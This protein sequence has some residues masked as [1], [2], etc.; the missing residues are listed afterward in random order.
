MAQVTTYRNGNGNGASNW[1]AIGIAGMAVTL[2][3]LNGF[4]QVAN[5]REDLKGLNTRFESVLSLREH[6]EFR[7]TL[8][9]SLDRLTRDVHD[10]EKEQNLRIGAVERLRL[11]EKITDELRKDH[12]DLRKSVTTTVTISGALEKL[13][14]EQIMLRE[15]INRL[16]T[17]NPVDFLTPKAKD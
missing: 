16:S 5:P 3:L 14:K 9:I 13:D 12:D 17:V 10:L 8:H 6:E 15:R 7:K 2:S 11:L 4:W 1:I